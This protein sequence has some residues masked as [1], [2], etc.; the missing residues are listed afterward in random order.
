MLVE[1][2]DEQHA[3]VV[4]PNVPSPWSGSLYIMTRDRFRRLDI[5]VAD[6]IGCL[7]RGGLGSGELLRGKI[8]KFE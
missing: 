3:A 8:P 6:A 2:I 1:E 5:T 7:K 4:I